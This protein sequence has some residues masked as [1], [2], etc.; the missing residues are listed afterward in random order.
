MVNLSAMV[1]KFC[2]SLHVHSFHRTVQLGF[3]HVVKKKLLLFCLSP[4][5]CN[6]LDA[7]FRH[8]Q[9]ILITSA[10]GHDPDPADMMTGQVFQSLMDA[11]SADYVDGTPLASRPSADAGEVL[12]EGTHGTGRRLSTGRLACASHFCYHP[13]RWLQ[14]LMCIDLSAQRALWR[15]WSAGSH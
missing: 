4:G 12:E 1:T 3:V 9:S 6:Q 13:L 10:H 7:F 2:L 11:D 8:S 5:K 14:R 15:G